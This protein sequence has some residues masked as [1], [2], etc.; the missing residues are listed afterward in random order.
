MNTKTGIDLDKED[1]DNPQQLTWTK[2][3]WTFYNN[4]LGQ[5]GL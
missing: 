5:R 1:F 2:T 3:T 4:R